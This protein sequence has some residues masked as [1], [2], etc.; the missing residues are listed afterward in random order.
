MIQSEI[1]RMSGKE[2]YGHKKSHKNAKRVATESA[3]KEGKPWITADGESV[4]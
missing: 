4:Q 1:L 3:K 2:R